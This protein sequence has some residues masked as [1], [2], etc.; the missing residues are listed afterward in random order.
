[1]ILVEY[2]NELASI[3]ICIHIQL[4]EA[5]LVNEILVDVS[6]SKATHPIDVLQT[7]NE[8]IRIFKVITFLA[9]KFSC[10]QCSLPCIE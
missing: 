4:Y 1:M 9:R 2:C 6:E 7:M 3:A 8:K 10:R 5:V